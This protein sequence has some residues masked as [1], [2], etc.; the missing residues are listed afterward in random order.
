MTAAER[1]AQR[2][3]RLIDT[4]IE[5]MGT[6]GA[7]ETTVTAV[8]ASSGVTSR[9]FYQHFGDRDALLAAAAERIAGLLAGTIVAAIPQSS[10]TPATMT[11]EPIRMLVELIQ[12]NPQLARILFVESGTEPVLRT[13][14][15]QV[16][17]GIAELMRQQARVRLHISDG[18]EKVT[19]LAATVGVGGLFEVFRRW[20]DGELDYTRD[21][22]VDHCAGLVTSLIDYVLAQDSADATL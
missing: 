18:A 5:L 9:Y 10:S 13:L 14:R 15:G 3:D 7:A 22:L 6:R 2:R 16:M 1:D 4:A 11:H 8:C 21:E 12:H 19:H 17:G 20:L